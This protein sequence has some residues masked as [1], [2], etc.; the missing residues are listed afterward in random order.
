MKLDRVAVLQGMI[1]TFASVAVPFALWFTCACQGPAAATGPAPAAAV[2]GTWAAA[3]PD[4]AA[5]AGLVTMDLKTDKSYQVTIDAGGKP[6]E[7]ER[8]A[9]LLRALRVVFFPST[10][11][12]APAAGA[13]LALIACAGP[14]SIPVPAADNIWIAN[15]TAGGG[16]FNLTFHRL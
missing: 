2:V 7:R 8:G 13:G 1:I 9:W 11:E 4:T 5:P 3:W 14:D 15:Y 16:L 12:A 6:V 10:C